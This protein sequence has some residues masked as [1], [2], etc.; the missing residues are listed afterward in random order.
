MTRPDGI[1]QRVPPTIWILFTALLLFFVIGGTF[2]YRSQEEHLRA[3]EE[4][5]LLAIAQLKV[6]EITRWRMERRGDATVALAGPFFSTAVKQW[7][8]APDPALAAQITERLESY[9]RGYRYASAFI[10]DATGHVRLS[11]GIPEGH[12]GPET[13]L[14]LETV[15][16]ERRPLLSELYRCSVHHAAHLDVIAPLISDTAEGRTA[17]AALILRVDPEE[18]LYPLIKLWPE[19]SDSA[20]TLLAR[21]DGDDA[22]FLNELRHKKGTALNLRIPLSRF[23]VPAVRAVRGEEGVVEGLDYRGVPVLSALKHIPGSSW[24]LIAKIDTAEAFSAWRFRAS[25]II[26]GLFLLLGL[27]FAG[28]G[29]YWY[30]QQGHHYRALYLTETARKKSESQYRAIFMNS[31]DALMTLAPPSWQFSSANPSTIEMFQTKD[32]AEFISLAPWELSP[33]RQPDGRLSVEKAKEMI[34][35]AVR[36]GYHFFEWTHRRLK[37]ENFAATVLLTRMELDDKVSLQAT[38]RDITE[39]K[40]QEEMLRQ[41]EE[42]F[43]KAF[44]ASPD[45]L[46]ITRVSDGRIIDSNE[47]FCHM[48]GYTKEEALKTSTIALDLWADPAERDRVVAILRERGSVRDHEASFRAKDGHL[49]YCLYAGEIIRLH[50]EPH[51]ISIVR[52]IT[53]RK[54]AEAALQKSEEKYRTI[55][56]NTNDAIYIH[57]LKGNIID[58]N[59]QACSMLGYKRE[60]LVGANLQKIDT[61][62]ISKVMPEQIRSLLI[63]GASYFEGAQV[64]KDGTIIFVDIGSKVISQEG[65]G[66]IVAFVRNVTDHKVLELAR[67]DLLASLQNKNEEMESILYAASH[68]L[69]SPLVNIQG[70]S[71]RIQRYLAELDRIL[72]M[73][74]PAEELCETAAPIIRNNIPKALGYVTASTDKMDA[75]VNGLLKLS[76][77]G[78]ATHSPEPIDMNELMRETLDALKF[79]TQEARAVVAL[80][81]LPFCWGDRREIGQAFS[82]LID[83]AIKY[84]DSDRP[85]TIRITGT[86]KGGRVAYSVEDT[87]IGIKKGHQDQIWGLFSRLDPGGP[88]PG[89][90]IGL[91]MVKR[92]IQR[93]R[94][95]IWMESEPGKGSSFYIVLPHDRT[96][97]AKQEAVPHT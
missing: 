5:K 44:H 35:I 79:Q 26:I 50:G 64:K 11:A 40:R 87:G 95:R 38:V 89:E 60:E 59:E 90:G 73:K 30:R 48:T 88:V 51:V 67:E 63:K 82:N 96:G 3:D 27:S 77:L 80:G 71:A 25:A 86:E 7:L 23:D 16:R 20:E 65:N 6:D 21:R 8:S 56:E 52:D 2:F 43:N 74:A 22:L 97:A 57:D 17:V 81:D 75:L 34:E 85:L 10:V 92:I 84:R 33:E 53:D 62:E 28:I 41:S 66:I 58:V 69:R 42:K 12:I 76:R 29:F 37:G 31:R 32:E 94:G 13:K 46:I 1:F 39:W 49:I 4:Q 45:T 91:T 83:N 78:R 68:D 47:E 72:T 9:R 93:N 61:Q 19:Q 14:Y 24:C 70:F 18:F 54:R 15:L 36:R 55:V